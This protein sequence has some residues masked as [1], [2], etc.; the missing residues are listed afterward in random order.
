ML[1]RELLC[2]TPHEGQKLNA[3]RD[4]SIFVGEGIWWFEPHAT[5]YHRLKTKQM[6]AN[7]YLVKIKQIG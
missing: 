5:E 3:K 1:D 6:K 2:W 4:T 7:A